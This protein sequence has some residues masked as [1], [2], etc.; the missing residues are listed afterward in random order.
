MPFRTKIDFSNNRQVKQYA[1]SQTHLSGGTSFGI[2]FSGLPTGP[3]LTTSGIS[4]SYNLITSY[5]SGTSG[6]TNYTWYDRR[7]GLGAQH[8][9]ALTPS[10]SATT[11]NTG[12][13]LTARTTT[14]IDGNPVVLSYSGVSFGLNVINMTNLGGGIYSGNIQTNV[15]NILT[16]DTL[17][18]TGRTIWVDTSGITRTEALIITETPRIGSIFSCYDSEGRGI[19]SDVEPII[20][21]S[22]YW[23]VD[24]I[25]RRA[26][27][28]SLGDHTIV[29]NSDNSIIV[30]GVENVVN[31]VFRSIILGGS[32]TT[33]TTNDMVYAPSI[34]INT[35]LGIGREPLYRFDVISTGNT[36][37][38]YLNDENNNIPNFQLSGSPTSLTF[39]GAAA[40]GIGFGASSTIIGMRGISEASFSAYGKN[41]DSFLYASSASNGLNIISNNGTNTE[42][43]IRFYAGGNPQFQAIPHMFILGSGSTKGYVGLNLDG[44]TENLDVSGNVRVRTIG[45]SA[46]AGALHY[47]ATGV[48][49]TNTSDERLKTNIIDLTDALNK[50]KNLRGVYYNWK[51]DE[52]GDKRIGFIAQEVNKIVPELTFVNQNSPDKY[53]GI[54][55]DN[56][57]A[58]LVEAV[59]ELSNSNNIVLN[60]QTI[61]AEDNNIELNYSGTPETAISGG[62]I[63]LHALGNNKSAEIITD[64]NGNWITNNDFKPNKLTI[65]KFTPVS[66]SDSNGVDGNI[67]RDDNFLYLKTNDKWK[68]IKLEDF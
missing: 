53:M 11:Q 12:Y 47:T 43:Y 59:K 19:W 22:T 21:G 56:V 8:L 64:K 14:V 17:Y 42:D 16:A 25:E 6:S 15:L 65:P 58:L 68:R 13:I 5:F 40:P 1:E 54:H 50:V 32:G 48:L 66:S 55:Y 35:K 45:S 20:S 61:T 31:D 3:D 49:T 4:E 27:R 33:A 34:K 67:T 52:N 9:S 2:S 18:Y 62:I 41:G 38:L 44:P 7:M 30:G 26:L 46:S 29:G 28:D 10:N 57:T 60:T 36:T 37:Q 51:E 24:G 63:V 23:I 39:M